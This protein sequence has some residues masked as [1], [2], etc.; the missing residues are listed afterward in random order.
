MTAT[1]IGI[2]LFVVAIALASAATAA[3]DKD[4]IQG[5]DR[6]WVE[7]VKAKDLDTIAT[8]YAED[9][10]FMPTGSPRVHGRSK[11]RDSWK[12][13][14][15]DP[16]Y[17]S[18]KFEPVEIGVSSSKDVAYDVGDYQFQMRNSAGKET[19]QLGKYV[20]VW[21]KVDGEWKVAADIFNPNELP[22]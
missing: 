15:D 3:G 4:I 2:A 9:G 17:V 18:L 5:L 12:A 16:S 21:K 7:A 13:M 19:T 10:Y 20:V 1:R 14:F 11:I 6:K 8:F 22:R